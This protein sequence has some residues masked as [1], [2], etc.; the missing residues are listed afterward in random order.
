MFRDARV[1]VVGACV[2]LITVTVGLVIGIAHSRQGIDAATTPLILTVLGLVGTTIPALIAAAFA[3][4]AARDIR[5]GVLQNQVRKGA[6]DALR[7]QRIADWD[8]SHG[9][10]DAP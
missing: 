5:N 8:A 3:E 9:R 10:K 6:H 1:A 4:R 2:A 7:E